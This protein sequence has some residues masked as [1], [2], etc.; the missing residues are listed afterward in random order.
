MDE[1][2]NLLTK[3]LENE[4]NENMM[5]LT[6]KKIEKIKTRV[7]KQ[8]V[9]LDNDLIKTYLLKLKDYIYVDSIDN[10]KE[11]SYLRWF[12][13]GDSETNKKK[14]NTGGLLV[15]VKFV[16]NETLLVCKNFVNKFK[17]NYYTLK[18]DNL[19]TFQKL[20]N[21]ELV[22]LLAMDYLEK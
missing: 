9:N 11:G 14:L 1:N 7:L 2:A 22:I 21:Q 15:E 20:N 12:D 10:L 5:K 18:F 4:K 3:A 16:D 8:I 19:V 13:I 17:N 6:T